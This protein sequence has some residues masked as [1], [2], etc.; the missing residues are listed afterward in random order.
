MMMYSQPADWSRSK[1]LNMISLHRLETCSVT[2]SCEEQ[3]NFAD[4]F[5]KVW[6]GMD[7]GMVTLRPG[8]SVTWNARLE[9][10][11]LRKNL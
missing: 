8:Q 2:P 4:P 11:A 10:L 1:G 5:S 7:T 6:N 3:F 9:L